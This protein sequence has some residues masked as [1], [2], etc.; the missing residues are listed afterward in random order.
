MKEQEFQDALLN[1]LHILQPASVFVTGL[2]LRY[3]IGKY[4]T[5]KTLGMPDTKLDIVEFD[6]Q[7]N[8]HLYELKLIDSMEI[9]TGKFFGQIML[10][11][12]LF[13]TEPWNELF[14]RFITRIN[15]DVNSVRGE[16]EKLT[17]HLAFDYGQ[18]EVADDN[19]P[20]AYFTSWNLVVCGGQGYE[21]AA[22]FN[23]VIWSFLNFGEQ[24]FTAS[25]P[26][27]DIYH[28]YKD[29]DHFVLKG[30]EETS[31]YQTNGLTEYARQQFNKDF[32]EFFKEE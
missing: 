18:G 1:Y 29:N 25:T 22:G 2:N 12:Y 21:L 7:Q 24:Y 19:D 13:S 3:E 11:D 32:P 4:H 26:H 8:F 17:G 16:W 31:L 30:L 10:Y 6:E 5:G 20:K 27:F 23:P 14:G 9:W 28:F 15:T